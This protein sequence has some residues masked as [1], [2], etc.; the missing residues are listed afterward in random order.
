MSGRLTP[1]AFTSI[2]TSPMPGS[3]I[4][5]LAGFSTSGFPGSVI[6]MAVMVA[7]RLGIRDVSCREFQKAG[8]T[9]DCVNSGNAG[10]WQQA[11][12]VQMDDEDDLP[13]SKKPVL[14]DLAPMA[15]AA[16]EDYIA[17]LETEIERARA[18]I[19]RKR[20]QKTGAEA[21]FKR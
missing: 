13:R 8:G 4:G 17:G 6:S 18:E 19:A 1:A 14:K 11:R 5:R 12:R 3:G 7:G 2:S 9:A 16:L 10:D 15:V 20:A 21:L